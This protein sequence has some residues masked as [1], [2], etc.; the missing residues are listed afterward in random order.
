MDSGN[1]KNR[2]INFVIKGFGKTNVIIGITIGILIGGNLVWALTKPYDFTSGNIISSAEVNSNF[3]TLYDQHAGASASLSAS[4]NVPTMAYT[5]IQFD[6]QDYG[7]SYYDTGTYRYTIPASGVYLV[8]YFINEPNTCEKHIYLD[9]AAVGG[10]EMAYA[11]SAPLNLSA[12][13]Y[14]EIYLYCSSMATTVATDS[15]FV[16]RRLF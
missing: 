8:A 13:Q 4:Q 2:I 6:V 5:K 15:T 10:M 12:G 3:D 16:V 14:V 9:G 11:G 7:D 1:K